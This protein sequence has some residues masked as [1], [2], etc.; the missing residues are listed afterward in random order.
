[1]INGELIIKNAT[2]T[3]A[4]GVINV[5]GVGNKLVMEGCKVE[6]ANR[7]INVLDG[8]E[9]TIGKDCEVSAAGCV[10]FVNTETENKSV[11]N[12]AG[13]IHCTDENY[14]I[15]GNGSATNKA[16]EINVLEGAEVT[17]ELDSA[18][19]MPI[20]GVVNVKGGL[21]EGKDGIYQKSGKVNVTGGV[22]RGNGNAEYKYSGNGS[23]AMGHG[24]VCEFTNY[25]S[26]LAQLN[27]AGGEIVS[28]Q[29]EAIGYVKSPKLTIEDTLEELVAANVTIAEGAVLVDQAAAEEVEAE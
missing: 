28:M 1:M 29:K 16:I 4:N 20:A 9:V 15:G 7:A 24:I 19:F 27:V 3:G 26:G 10:V 22:V 8:A 5:E 21:V 12:V 14:A 17:S 2:V 6:A 23:N 25:P 11:L 13:K 18:I